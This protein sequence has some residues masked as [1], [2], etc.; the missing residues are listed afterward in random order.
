M[1]GDL[2]IGSGTVRAWLQPLPITLPPHTKWNHV[3]GVPCLPSS[4][5]AIGNPHRVLPH[6]S[7]QHR[8]L[9]R[10]CPKMNLRYKS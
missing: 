8:E 2:I 3:P 10:R 1:P 7:Q 9:K 5:A 4:T 6:K